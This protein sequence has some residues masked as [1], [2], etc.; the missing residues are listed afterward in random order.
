MTLYHCDDG[1]FEEEIE[2]DSPREAARQYVAA[3]E[4]GD[5]LITSWVHVWVWTNDEDRD[6]IRVPIE[7][8]E[9]ECTSDDHDWR[10]PL[11]VVGG[12]KENPG[13]YGHG[14]GVTITE[15]CKHCGWYRITDTWAQDPSTGEQGLE[16]IEYREP[17]DQSLEWVEGNT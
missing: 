7:P 5:D 4:W 14:A 3:G 8:T 16:S 1:N 15:V 13:V 12:L 17:D 10:N 9:P 6:R 11:S 2:A